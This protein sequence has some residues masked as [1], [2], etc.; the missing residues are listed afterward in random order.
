[1]TTVHVLRRPP[2]RR[3]G[4]P[5]AAPELRHTFRGLGVDMVDLT[6]ETAAASSQA[7]QDALE[8]G[9]VE[10]VAAVGG[11]GLVHLVVQALAETGVPLTILPSGTGNDFAAAL[12]IHEP[13]PASVLLSPSPVDLLRVSR[14]AEHVRWIASVAIAGFPAQINE[15]A[16]RIRFPIGGMVYTL[17]AIAELPRFTRRRF[18]IEVDGE[19][20]STDSAMLAIGNTCFMGGGMLVCP[21]ATP[22]DGQAH[23]TTI[24]GVGRLGLLRHLAFQRG[25]TADRPEVLRRTARQVILH[26]PTTDVWG[27]GEY[28]AALPLRID[29]VPGALAVTLPEA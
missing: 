3:G 10:R 29:V 21:D 8:Q 16:N 25:G 18:D 11:D 26:G 4:P 9:V 7:L 14:D 15:R 6:G 20:L 1:M 24:D 23:L 17:A 19:P 13:N 2:T 27:D 22:T 12:G 28:V 5:A